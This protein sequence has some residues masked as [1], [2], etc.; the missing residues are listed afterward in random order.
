[1]LPAACAACKQQR[2]ASPSTT[3]CHTAQEWQ[4]PFVNVFKLCGVEQQKRDA[5]IS[6]KVVAR[7]D[8]A[9][10]RRVFRITGAIPAVNY[11]K[12]PKSRGFA[13]HGRFCYLQ[14]RHLVPASVCANSSNGALHACCS[15]THACNIIRQQLPKMICSRMRCSRKHVACLTKDLS[16]AVNDA[17]AVR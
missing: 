16:R 7:M 8:D 4:H 14:V 15:C 9:I 12:L 5:E 3:V 10:H 2:T 13:L 11:L 17:P 1:M 6:G